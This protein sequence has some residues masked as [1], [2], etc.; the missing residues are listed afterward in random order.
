M[1]IS[2]DSIEG[3]NPG[4]ENGEVSVTITGGE[5]PYDFFW[6]G[7]TGNTGLED[8]DDLGAGEWILTVT[9]NDGCQVT[10]TVSV[11]VG[12]LEWLRPE[13]SL[14]PNPT[15]DRLDIRFESPFQGTLFLVDALGREVEAHAM[16]GTRTTWSL[17]GHPAGVYMVRAMGEDGRRSAARLVIG[18]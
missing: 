12:I 16:R 17:A 10:D 15:R 11:P 1:T 8:P 4:E 13:F 2:F 5:E 9:D 3:A 6:T 18:D 14:A 7:P